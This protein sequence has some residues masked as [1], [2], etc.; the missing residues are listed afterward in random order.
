MPPLPEVFSG[1]LLP[2]DIHVPTN[3]EEV[4]GC[5]C[6]TAYVAF[7]PSVDGTGVVWDNGALDEAVRPEPWQTWASQPVVA[8]VLRRNNLFGNRPPFHA[9]LLDT[10]R[11]RFWVAD[12]GHVQDFLRCH[13]AAATE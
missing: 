9:L 10:A 12:E 11:R 2:L 8:E 5:L 13:L 4:L 3:F 6:I 1:K 7:V